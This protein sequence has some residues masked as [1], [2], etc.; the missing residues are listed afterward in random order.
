M[1]FIK[2][3]D[4]CRVGV[5]ELDDQHKNL[6]AI[7]N[8]L[9][10]LVAE[11]RIAEI[12][13]ETIE[14]L[15]DY[16]EKHFTREEELMRQAGYPESKEHHEEHR[17]MMNDVLLFKSKYIAGDLDES[18]VTEFLIEWIL[19]HVKGIDRQYIGQMAQAGIR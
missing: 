15:V 1:D 18:A 11:N 19:H 8:R 7:C 9:I 14:E 4:T 17:K 12:G 16:T 3:D 5:K 6:F 2:W 10:R 13:Q